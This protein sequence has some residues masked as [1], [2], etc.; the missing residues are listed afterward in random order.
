MVRIYPTPAEGVKAFDS[1]RHPEELG[2]PALT[3]IENYILMLACD[4]GGQFYSRENAPNPIAQ[5]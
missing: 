2:S 4:L 5:Q 3:A 1:P